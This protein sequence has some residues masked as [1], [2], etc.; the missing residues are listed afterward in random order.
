MGLWKNLKYVLSD[1]CNGLLKLLVDN[2]N[3]KTDKNEK[4]VH[5][6]LIKVQQTLDTQEVIDNNLSDTYQE[7]RENKEAADKIYEQYS[8]ISQGYDKIV[9][10]MNEMEQKSASRTEEM[11][12]NFG[13]IVEK[14]N[15]EFAKRSQVLSSRI[16]E[17]FELIEAQNVKDPDEP[18][19]DE[20]L[21]RIEMLE[22][23]NEEYEN[24]L[25]ALQNELNRSQEAH[26]EAEKNYQAEK[27]KTFDLSKKLVQ[28]NDK[29]SDLLSRM[30]DRALEDMI[31]KDD[32]DAGSPFAISANKEKYTITAGNVQ[33]MVMKFAN[34]SVLDRFFEKVPDH[35]S[36]KKMYD[37]YQRNIRI[38]ARKF[39]AG[40]DLEEVLEAFLAVVQEDLVNKMMEA[41]SRKIKAGNADFE[42]KLLG[43]LN[44]YLESAGFYSRDEIKPGQM[45]QK[46]SFKDME[47]V[48]ADNAD[49]REQGEIVEVE[50]YPYYINY[51]DK[52]G[53]RKRMHTQGVMAV[54]G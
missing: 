25:M 24:Q 52:S 16:R 26:Q 28:S 54:A 22:K 30:K 33:I 41:V 40:A 36:Y 11:E 17:I 5:D 51:I 13:D 8:D 29:I 21:A 47:C 53:K 7:L 4:T 12:K 46:E 45:F 27:R 34:T 6:I 42:E 23:K 39:S 38:T 2:Y 14:Q 31:K 43:V 37:S 10:Q 48:R 35:D 19:V 32:T 3:K 15:E 18:D 49:G 44:R 50:I 1:E 9:S 20:L